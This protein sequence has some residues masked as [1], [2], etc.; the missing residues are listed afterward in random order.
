VDKRVKKTRGAGTTATL[1]DLACPHEDDVRISDIA[2][3]LALI[4]RFQGGTRRPYSLAEHALLTVEIAERE[5]GLRAPQALLACLLYR[6][7]AAY[8][9]DDDA[10]LWQLLS[11]QAGPTARIRLQGVIQ[12]AFALRTASAAYAS[13]VGSADGRARATAARD[14]IDDDMPRAAALDDEQA[15]DW[16]SL[17]ERD[18]LGW[19]DWRTAFL[20]KFGELQFARDV[21]GR[22]QP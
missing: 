20:D 2:H 5:Q 22:G 18:G 11:P 1:I 14:L 16:L 9:G 15:V 19:L 12:R 7:H 21:V 6:A 10:P 3:R 13:A 17:R 8:L 4:N